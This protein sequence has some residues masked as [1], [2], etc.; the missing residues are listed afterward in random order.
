MEICW[1]SV[2]YRNT[3]VVIPSLLPGLPYASSERE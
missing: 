1:E 2:E 3:G